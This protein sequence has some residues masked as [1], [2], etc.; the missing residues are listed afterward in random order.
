MLARP[1]WAAMWSREA[2]SPVGRRLQE[3]LYRLQEALYRLR[4]AGVAEAR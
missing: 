4:A 3:V 1:T 2:W